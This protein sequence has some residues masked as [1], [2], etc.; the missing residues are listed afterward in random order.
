MIL[1]P[2]IIVLSVVFF[3]FMGSLARRGGYRGW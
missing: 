2:I 1:A 3:I